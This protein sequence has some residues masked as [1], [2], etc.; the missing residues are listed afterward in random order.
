MAQEKSSSI[1]CGTV[2][3]SRILLR[4]H[5]PLSMKDLST[6]SIPLM[7]EQRREVPSRNCRDFVGDFHSHIPL[8]P[9]SR[10]HKAREMGMTSPSDRSVTTI[11]Y[12]LI[13]KSHKTKTKKMGQGSLAYFCY[14]TTAVRLHHLHH[15]FKKLTRSPRPLFISVLWLLDLLTP[16]LSHVMNN[17]Q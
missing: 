7:G 16:Q 11:P 8:S 10:F 4:Y 12:H 3:I 9:E 14:Y 17:A 2:R 6:H 1:L 13:T 5:T 15:E